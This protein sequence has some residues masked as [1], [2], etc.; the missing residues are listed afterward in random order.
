[1]MYAGSIVVGWA[2]SQSQRN[3]YSS[4]SD[5][6]SKCA[7]RVSD[8]Y[9]ILTC[10]GGSGCDRTKRK[11]F[12]SKRQIKEFLTY[13]CQTLSQHRQTT[14]K[15]KANTIICFQHLAKYCNLS[16]KIVAFKASKS[17]LRCRGPKQTWIQFF[18]YFFKRKNI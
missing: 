4:A 12:F 15:K 8:T 14:A 5:I 7:L 11:I 6:N 3:I 9:E 10:L 13:C 2:F 18:D 1:M 16:I 17:Y